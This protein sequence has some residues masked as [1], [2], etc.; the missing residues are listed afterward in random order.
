MRTLLASFGAALAAGMVTFA[1]THDGP[2]I[3]DPVPP[4]GGAGGDAPLG[5]CNADGVCQA[6]EGDGCEGDCASCNLDTVCGPGEDQSCADCAAGCNLDSVCQP[7]EGAGCAD[8]DPTG[9]CDDDGVCE[10]G[11]N[12][13]CADCTTSNCHLDGIC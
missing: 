6:T 7:S 9:T 2:V 10:A 4:G 1:C 12:P 13:A 3:E 8:C 5:A 11:E